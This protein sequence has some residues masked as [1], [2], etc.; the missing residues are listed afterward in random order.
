MIKPNLIFSHDWHV[1]PNCQRSLRVIRLSGT[2][3][4]RG[5]GCYAKVSSNLLRSL[6][7]AFHRDYQHFCANFLKLSDFQLH[8]KANPHLRK[9]PET[10]CWRALPRFADSRDPSGKVLPGKL[11]TAQNI[12]QLPA[13]YARADRARRRIFPL[14]NAMA[15]SLRDSL[16]RFRGSCLTCPNEPA[17]HFPHRAGHTAT[18]RLH[19]SSAT[20]QD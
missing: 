7:I 9:G 12:K 3:L 17:S 11:R 19:C 8:V 10:R 20:F 15:C 2:L 13:K 6:K 4:D 1:Q 18:G 14:G 5:P 16:Q